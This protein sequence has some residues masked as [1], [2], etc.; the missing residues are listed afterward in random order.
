[1][2]LQQWGEWIAYEDQ[3]QTDAAT[4][5]GKQFWYNHLAQVNCFLCVLAPGLAWMVVIAWHD[6]ILLTV[7]LSLLHLK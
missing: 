2:R 6:I 3:S 7:L 5:Q 1:M 4:G